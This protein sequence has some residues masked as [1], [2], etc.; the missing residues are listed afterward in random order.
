MVKSPTTHV[1]VAGRSIYN[2]ILYDPRVTHC[3]KA[4]ITAF[5]VSNLLISYFYLIV[6]KK[7]RIW[8]PVVK[9][10]ENDLPF[11]P[12]FLF[13][14]RTSTHPHAYLSVHFPES[15]TLPRTA[16]AYVPAPVIITSRRNHSLQWHPIPSAVIISNHSSACQDPVDTPYGLTLTLSLSLYM[17]ALRPSDFWILSICDGLNGRRSRPK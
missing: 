1:Y 15:P 16:P 13:L 11:L 4:N 8:F 9:R 12:L 3:R 5:N 17:P 6:S 10:R 14:S 2:D 7:N